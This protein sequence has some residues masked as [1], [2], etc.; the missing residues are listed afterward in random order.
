VALQG[1]GAVKF[2]AHRPLPSIGKLGQVRVSR[3]RSGR[4]WLSIAVGLPDPESG[5]SVGDQRAAGVTGIDFGVLNFAAL[6]TGEKIDGPRPG[7]AIRRELRRA[8]RA[9]TQRKRGSRSR[10]RAVRALARTHEK[11]AGMRRTHHHTVARKLVREHSVLAIEDLRIQNMT[12]SA[13]GTVEH[14]GARVAQKAG[15]NRA[16]L[17]QGWAEFAGILAAKAEEVGRLVVRVDARG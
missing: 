5:G 17:E 8:Q 15:L 10:R 14:P 9:V 4:W 3:S 1:V 2:R 7:G 13:R 16:I 6:S 12:R 11:V